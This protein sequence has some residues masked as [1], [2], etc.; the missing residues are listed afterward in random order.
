MRHFH[1]FASFSGI[2]FSLLAGCAKPPKPAP[3][4]S[5][6]ANPPAGEVVKI[7]F[8]AV[9]RPASVATVV[10]SQPESMAKICR[11]LVARAGG[12]ATGASGEDEE[13]RT[14]RRAIMGR[15]RD[16]IAGEVA[17]R[18]SSEIVGSSGT[19]ES[20]ERFKALSEAQKLVLLAEKTGAQA[21]L[22]LDDA[23][24][25]T[26]PGL[27]E[28]SAV[29]RTVVRDKQQGEKILGCEGSVGKFEI[30]QPI[31]GIRAK[32]VS[33]KKDD[34]S[35]LADIEMLDPISEPLGV[36]EFKK[37]EYVPQT[38]EYC[39]DHMWNDF[40]DSWT[41]QKQTET[42]GYAPKPI[43]C[44]A[45]AKDLL[46]EMEH[47]NAVR[48]MPK[49]ATIAEALALK[50]FPTELAPDACKEPPPA[51]APAP[52]PAKPAPKG[53]APAAKPK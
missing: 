28:V 46:S 49:F 43:W 36:R 41:C 8:D 3:D 40:S 42:I 47:I 4:A 2:A 19:Q 26:I 21:L 35:I 23:G 30:G 37:F 32:L 53:K 29:G 50:L 7:D 17:A 16:V 10:Q 18:V 13:I 1:A 52:E 33:L 6:A 34:A 25:W 39:P 48:Y 24:R 9:L 44:E 11:V 38:R 22:V 31:A 5:Q 14:L 15:H 45:F 27:V 12:R 20:V 51:P